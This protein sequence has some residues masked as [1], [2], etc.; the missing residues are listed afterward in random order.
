MNWKKQFKGKWSRK[1][2]EGRSS[3][4]RRKTPTKQQ[5]EQPQAVKTAVRATISAVNGLSI[6][7]RAGGWI[8]LLIIVVIW[9]VALF[10]GPGFD[11]FFGGEDT[12]TGQTI[13]T[14][15]ENQSRGHE[16]YWRDQTDY[17]TWQGRNHRISCRIEGCLVC[18][19]SSV[20]TDE[21]GRQESSS[22]TD[23]NKTLLTD[24]FWNMHTINYSTQHRTETEF[25][26]GVDENS[27]LIT[28]E[29]EEERNYLLIQ[30]SHKPP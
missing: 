22:M 17:R 26:E 9:L 20:T 23:A 18:L 24:I 21:E 27:E 8:I 28:V 15:S 16:P 1:N 10:V 25:T 11:V 7:L 5:G 12:G 2:K 3:K 6:F 4:L 14:D 19:C 30:V 13:R 29:N